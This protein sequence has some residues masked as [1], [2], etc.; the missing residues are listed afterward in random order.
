[1]YIIVWI[2][3]IAVFFTI[4]YFVVK[5]AVRNAIIEARVVTRIKVEIEDEISKTACPSCGGEHDM[6]FPKCPFCKHRY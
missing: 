1:M 4:L 5:N 2:F 3:S 6:D